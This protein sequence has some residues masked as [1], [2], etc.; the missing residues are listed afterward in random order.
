MVIRNQCPPFL[1]YTLC[2]CLIPSARLCTAS[3]TWTAPCSVTLVRVRSLLSRR[4]YPTSGS[5]CHHSTPDS[6]PSASFSE[7]G[8]ICRFQGKIDR[9]KSRLRQEA[10]SRIL[11]RLTQT[12]PK[13]NK[14][15]LSE[16]D[17]AC[18]HYCC[19]VR[20]C[21]FPAVW[22]TMS[23]L[24]RKNSAYS[25]SCASTRNDQEEIVA[26]LLIRSLY[27]D[28]LLRYELSSL[29]EIHKVR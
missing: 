23:W 24:F 29:L 20:T 2:A 9:E 16:T 19:S 13:P 3:L 6:R 4:C 12:Y 17:P 21:G 26:V 27:G 7:R 18:G 14:L 25:T 15:I 22:L 28:C 1:Q 5:R 10:R 8:S 11:A